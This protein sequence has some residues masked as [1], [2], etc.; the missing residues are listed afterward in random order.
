[1]KWLL[2]GL[3]CLVSVIASAKTP[4]VMTDLQG[5]KVSVDLPV[6]KLFLIDGR[7]I[8]SV[9]IAGEKTLSHVLLAGVIR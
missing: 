3:L 5:R 4:T 8:L 1:M 6:D 7:D 9:D 2:T